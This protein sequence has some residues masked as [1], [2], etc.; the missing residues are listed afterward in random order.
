[1][2]KKDDLVPLAKSLRAE[3]DVCQDEKLEN[4]LLM[5]LAGVLKGLGGPRK[6]RKGRKRI[7]RGKEAED[8]R[9]L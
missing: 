4:G 6:A 3:L 9:L 8:R 5:R 1:M 2:K 7:R